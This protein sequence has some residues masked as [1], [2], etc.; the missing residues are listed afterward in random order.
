[1]I[2]KRLKEAI[3][4]QN[5]FAVALEVIIVVLGVVIGFQISAWAERQSELA[6]EKNYLSQIA[7]DIETT[8]DLA[9]SVNG[10]LA[11][12]EI[13]AEQ[14]F[15]SF[16]KIEPLPDDSVLLLVSKTYAYYP[17][18]PVLGTIEALIGTGDLS[19]IQNDSLRMFIPVF[20]EEM[21]LMSN[22]QD[23]VQDEL[24]SAM[25][26]LTQL[27]DLAEA[28]AVELR[29]GSAL[30]VLAPQ[31]KTSDSAYSTEE[32]FPF[33]AADFQRNREAY[34]AVYRIH[35]WKIQSKVIRE[36][37]ISLSDDLISLMN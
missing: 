8:R 9:V 17:V 27:V 26:D 30:E 35:H 20:I 37:Y 28:N 13:S 4:E 36:S 15:N 29:K 11:E 31:V 1:M 21:R 23:M 19:L 7:Q 24:R 3:L 18:H 16:R 5:W 2:L 25:M 34:N 10:L 14:L 12:S 22:L 33:S 32:L 6:T